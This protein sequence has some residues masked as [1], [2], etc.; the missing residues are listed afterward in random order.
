MIIYCNPQLAALGDFRVDELVGK[1]FFDFIDPEHANNT[2]EWHTRRML[3]EIEPTRYETLVRHSAGKKIPVEV[4]VSIMEHAGKP[5]LLTIIRDITEQ[6]KAEN[7]LLEHV[8]NQKLL[9]DITLAA[10]ESTELNETLQIIVDRLGELINADGCFISLWNPQSQK[11]VPAAAYGPMRETY[12]K[13]VPK[14]DEPTVTEAALQQQK[15]IVINDVLNSPYI[16]KE[17][18]EKFPACSILTL[19]LIVDGQKLGAALITFN[20]HHTFTDKEIALG[21]QAS[22]QVALA[23]LKARLLDT[24]QQRAI[25]AETLREAGAA[26]A[27]NLKLDEAIDSILEQL[28]QVVPYDS[29]S[30]QLL[31]DGYLTI[32]GQHG[33]ED[34]SSVLGMKFALSDDNPNSIVL[35]RCQTY[36]I[37]NAPEAY[38]N[39]NKEPHNHIRGWMGVPLLVHD[40][41]IGML[42]LD[43]NNPDQ[44]NTEHS[45]LVSAFAA[46]VAIALDNANLYEETH[47]LAITDS[48][49]DIYNRRQ[50]MQ[51]AQQELHRARRYQ[52]PVSIIMMDIDHFKKVNDTYGHLIGDQVLH[53]IAQICKNDLREMDIIGRYGG[54]EFAI[55]LPETPSFLDGTKTENADI[56]SAKTVAERLCQ[57]LNDT[58]LETIK[59]T[60]SVTASFGIVGMEKDMDKIETLLDRADTAL[61]IAKQRGRNQVAIWTDTTKIT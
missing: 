44:F 36:I 37:K 15:P 33:F 28:N 31:Q 14:P 27:A 52:R 23:I 48:L 30:V 22:H 7:I 19:P 47:R 25:E 40:R 4:N 13:I 60:I 53:D 24:A 43:S 3:G 56:P 1:P 5:A 2:H 6:V 49:T 46:Q 38:K 16:S 21:E 61:Y 20:K 26:V 9:N 11:A 32:V 42:A 34:P 58:L 39:F 51:L 10:I 12:Q 54:E 50:F 59:G 35:E 18:A 41:V 8:R 57:L 17:L 45:R 55:L 29:A